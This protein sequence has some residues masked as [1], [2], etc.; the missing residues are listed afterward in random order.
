MHNRNNI[1]DLVISKAIMNNFICDVLPGPY[2]SD[3]L[4]VQFSIQMIREQP[5]CKIMIYHD[6][7]DKG[8]HNVFQ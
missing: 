3:H 5:R 8:A 6:M 7:K 1:L 4:D 2:I